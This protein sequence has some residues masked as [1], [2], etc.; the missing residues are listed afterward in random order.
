MTY[1]VVV[2]VA[3]DIE[4]VETDGA[5]EGVDEGALGD[6]GVGPHGDCHVG[7]PLLGESI[8]GSYNQGELLRDQYTRLHR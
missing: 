8:P 5:L 6:L 1:I 2:K 4:L 7:T 3:V